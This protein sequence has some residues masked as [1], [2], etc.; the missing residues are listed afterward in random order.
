MGMR[1]GGNE[2]PLQD[3][4]A[5]YVQERI[6]L[7]T[8][9]NRMDIST[10]VTDVPPESSMSFSYKQGWKNYLAQVLKI[11]ERMINMCADAEKPGGNTT[12]LKNTLQDEAG[13][14]DELATEAAK[15]GLAELQ[16]MLAWEAQSRRDVAASL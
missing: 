12:A 11:S 1:T 5:D 7:E 6:M 4:K 3:V 14:Y 15:R 2:M 8:W 9:R 16:A 13:K 10:P